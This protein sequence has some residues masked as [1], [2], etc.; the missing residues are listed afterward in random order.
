MLIIGSPPIMWGV[1]SRAPSFS[2]PRF[3]PHSRGDLGPAFSI[4]FLL[5]KVERN[6][7]ICSTPFGV[8]GR[9]TS[10]AASCP[11]G[12]ACAQRLSASEDGSHARLHQRF[13]VSWCSTPFGVRGRITS[14]AVRL[15]PVPISCSTP[16]GVRGR[17]TS[18]KTD[19]SYSVR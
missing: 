4:T 5:K 1:R 10:F 3:P 15:F 12:E 8:R 6:V 13:H 16:F 9:I 11:C 18:C 14:I 19:D 7:M 2:M 17:I